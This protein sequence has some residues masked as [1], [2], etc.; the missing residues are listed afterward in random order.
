[1]KYMLF[2]RQNLVVIVG[3]CLFCGCDQGDEIRSYDVPKEQSGLEMLDRRPPIMAQINGSPVKIEEATPH[4]VVVALAMREDATWFFKVAGPPDDV[5]KAE[6]QW[7]PVMEKLKFD[8][9]GEPVFDVPTEWVEK[10]QSQFVYKTFEIPGFEPPLVF[11]V[12]QLSAGQD[13]VANVNRWRV[14]QL[15][16][17][18]A[19]SETL[20]LKKISTAAGEM[21]LFDEVGTSGGGGMA[22]MMGRNRP[23]AP[24]PNFQTLPDE[25]F[26]YEI[27]DGWQK[28]ESI[29]MVKLKLAQADGDEKV[30]ITV[31]Q[32]DAAVNEWEPNAKTWANQI[33]LAELSME[34]LDKRTSNY[35]V[36]QYDAKKIRL[37]EEGNDDVK[38]AIVALM[39]KKGPSAW[40][41][42]LTGDKNL[43]IQKEKEFGQLISSFTFVE[44]DKVQE[45]KDSASK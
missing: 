40:F 29:P 13:L 27:A 5:A 31:T 26:T 3:F 43:V 22:P 30:Q 21:M 37:I 38:M 6:A 28:V 7:R 44:D 34:E 42:K 4:R 39:F 35:Q 10:G 23:N 17:E 36:D 1:M 16:I 20:N 32:M 15:G 12:S 33:G 9:Q 45:E 25:K 14:S 24:E 41:F 18:A 8:D 19:T 11:S 2:L